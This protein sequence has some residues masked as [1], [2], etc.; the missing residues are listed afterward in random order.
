MF[1]NECDNKHSFENFES[2]AYFRIKNEKKPD[3][4][5]LRTL[6][7]IYQRRNDLRKTSYEPSIKFYES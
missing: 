1:Q 5:F 4:T 6:N 2:F 3:L 7:Q